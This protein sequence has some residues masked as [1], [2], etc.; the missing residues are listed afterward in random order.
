MKLKSG[1]D[2][3]Y[4]AVAGEFAMRAHGG[5]IDRLGRA[6]LFFP[7]DDRDVDAVAIGFHADP[8]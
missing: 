3:P 4:P 6:R 1:I 8:E 2:P 7:V 5:E